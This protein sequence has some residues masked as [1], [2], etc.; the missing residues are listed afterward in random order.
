MTVRGRG[1]LDT[2]F[3]SESAALALGISERT[4]RSWGV[5][6]AER[7]GRRPLYR[8]ADII[9]NRLQ[10]QREALERQRPT[11]ES[12]AELLDLVERLDTELT[13]RRAQLLE[14]KNAGRRGERI[15]A[16]LVTIALG[17]VV[18]EV[19]NSLLALAAALKRADPKIN[20]QVAHGIRALVTDK[21][22]SVADF[23]IS[24]LFQQE[25]SA[26]DD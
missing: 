15:D 14:L 25:D 19:G 9:A 22:N 7:D 2:L 4:L 26:R 16:Q 13:G 6:P 17:Q 8:A 18:A 20:A 23:N 10:A 11:P 5:A 3:S 21:M 1:P 12:P 24:S